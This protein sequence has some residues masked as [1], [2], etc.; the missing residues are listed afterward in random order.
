M[1]LIGSASTD[2]ASGKLEI[3][4]RKGAGTKGMPKV[5]IRGKNII[6]ATMTAFKGKDAVL[7]T[8]G[9]NQDPAKAKE[10]T[11]LAS[12][13]DGGQLLADLL[14]FASRKIGRIGEEDGAVL[15]SESSL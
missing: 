2:G 9:Q 10:T 4:E 12:D 3:Y 7:I 14:A 1:W 5:T 11:F 15:N 8:D 13:A 6:S